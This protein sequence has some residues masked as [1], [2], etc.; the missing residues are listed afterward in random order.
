MGQLSKIILT[1]KE[2]RYYTV[3]VNDDNSSIDYC[4]TL[5][6]TIDFV[7]EVDNDIND[8]IEEHRQKGW[9]KH[10]DVEIEVTQ[11]ILEEKK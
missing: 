8:I 2:T 9:L 4:H 11:R 1:V 6:D 7:N 3:E 5:Q 10:E